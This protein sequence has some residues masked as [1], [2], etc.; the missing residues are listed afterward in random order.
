M[1]YFQIVRNFFAILTK[2]QECILKE[3]FFGGE[4][5]ILEYL[6]NYFDF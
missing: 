4:A 5:F 3:K 6:P 2:V 1:K